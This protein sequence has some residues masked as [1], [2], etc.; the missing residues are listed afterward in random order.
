MLSY[1]S[2]HILKFPKTVSAVNAMNYKFVILGV[3]LLFFADFK[4][5][6]QTTTI[7][8]LKHVA[9]NSADSSKSELFLLI[10]KK[11]R[12]INYD[13]VVSY[14]NKAIDYA[15]FIEGNEMIIES[16][17]E[18]AYI[19]IDIGNRERSLDYYH[20]AIQ[21]CLEEENQYLLAKIYIDKERYYSSM[22]DYANAIGSLDYALDIINSNNISSLKPVIYLNYGYLYLIIKDFKLAKYYAKQAKSFFENEREEPIFISSMS[23]IGKSFF[24]NNE[25]DSSLYY[26]T[27]ALHLA[28]KANSKIQLQKIYRN[29][30]AYYIEK[31]D[32]NKSNLY[33]D[34]SITF[35]NELVLPVEL[36][37]LISFKAHILSLKGDYRNTLK[38]NLQALELRKQTGVKISICYALL[39]IGGNYTQVGEYENA[40][41]YL[42]EGVKIAEDQNDIHSLVYGYDKFS[43]L[44][45]SEGNYEKALY[46]N[47]L[48]ISYNDSLFNKR[49]NDKVLFLKNQFELEQEKVFSEKIKLKEKA[50]LTIFLIVAAILSVCIIIILIWLNYI[51]EK[52]NKEITKAKED[53]EE[54]EFFFKDSQ[55]AASIGSY[56]LDYITG[57]WNSSDVLDRIFGVDK[58]YLLTFDNWINIIHQEDKE[59]ITKY[60]KEEV[61]SERQQF[62]KEFRIVERSN[63]EIKWVLGIGELVFDDDGNIISMI[64]TIQDITKRKMVEI[65]LLEY[66]E[67]LEVL[68][69]ERTDDL[70][71]KNEELERLNKLFTGREYR[72]QELKD[73]IKGLE[74]Q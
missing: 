73:K 3:F 61:I 15:T 67:K 18:L 2:C 24:N 8:S 34:S 71:E 16:L 30:S 26:Y 60:F 69:K 49:T 12:H 10:A 51:R 63:G 62:N 65:E 47:E 74:E 41:L 46:F 29:I 28:K 5:V 57:I 64:G 42:N 35:C 44:Y 39:N 37:A 22:S 45:K 19:N 25:L 55:N 17:I 14:S 20:Q 56:K 53:F 33:I 70:E 38:Y 50:N 1:F 7:D 40:L 48:K 59:M 11:Y 43:S 72:I 21:L 68:V 13:S 6:S 32:Y 66:R 4:S 58:D 9:S 52:T 54:S 27:S 31:E 23:L 36:A